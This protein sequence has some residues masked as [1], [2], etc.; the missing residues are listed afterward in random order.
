M[1]TNKHGLPS[2]KVNLYAFVEQLITVLNKLLNKDKCEEIKR[3]YDS[4]ISIKQDKWEKYNDIYH[5]AFSD[6]KNID[7]F[8]EN[9]YELCLK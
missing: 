3:L 2:G 4:T 6:R 5:N 7:F 9:R 8:K 1:K